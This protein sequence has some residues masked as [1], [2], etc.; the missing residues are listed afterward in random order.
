M[1][2]ILMEKSMG[3]LRP[4]SEEAHRVLANIAGGT[5]VVVDVRD[6]RRRSNQQ[7]A[8]WHAILDLIWEN[9]ESVQRYY[10]QFDKFKGGLLV[11]L[12]YRDDFQ[13]KDGSVASIPRSV[14]FASMEQAEF[15]KLVDDTLE[16]AQNDLG[17]D[18][19]TLSAEAKS[20]VSVP[21]REKTEGEGVF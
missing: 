4:A 12:G 16:F 7:N 15:T 21:T 14:S 1:S 20:R 17:F 9:H 18:R 13:M 11:R 10:G 8:Y 3:G 19:E 5:K 6:P 2:K